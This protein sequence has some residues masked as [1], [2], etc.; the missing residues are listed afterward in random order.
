MFRKTKTYTYTPESRFVWIKLFNKIAMKKCMEKHSHKFWKRFIQNVFFFKSDRLEHQQ[1][2]SA[3][4]RRFMDLPLHWSSVRVFFIN[5]KY[6]YGG[7]VSCRYTTNKPFAAQ[8]VDIFKGGAL[9]VACALLSFWFPLTRMLRFLSH[10]IVFCER[11]TSIV[12]L[13]SNGE[14]SPVNIC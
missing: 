5:Q 1:V 11:K 14:K 3:V 2:G 13:V 12:F 6:S 8:Q 10:C 7:L 9:G 4:F